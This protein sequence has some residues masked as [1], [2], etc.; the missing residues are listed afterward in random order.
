[1]D[2]IDDGHLCTQGAAAS[3]RTDVRNAFARNWHR[4]NRWNVALSALAVEKKFL[5][6]FLPWM[7][8]A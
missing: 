7:R 6:P 3:Q 8:P 2:R 4:A 1:L 5:M